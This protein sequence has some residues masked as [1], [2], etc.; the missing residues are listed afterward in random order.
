MSKNPVMLVPDGMDAAFDIIDGMEGMV[1]E[2]G[3]FPDKFWKKDVFSRYDS[4]AAKMNK[5]HKK[6]TMT[7]KELQ[8]LIDEAAKLLYD[9]IDGL[10]GVVSEQGEV[11]SMY[12]K[13]G[14]MNAAKKAYSALKRA[15]VASERVAAKSL[16]VHG[17]SWGERPI[18]EAKKMIKRLGGRILEDHVFESTDG[19]YK[20]YIWAMF[21]NEK[22]ADKYFSF[23]KRKLDKARY[24]D[25]SDIRKYASVPGNK[26]AADIL[27]VAGKLE[28]RGLAT[29]IVVK[30]FLIGMDAHMDALIEA[31]ERLEKMQYQET[32]AGGRE[33]DQ[34]ITD[35]IE[36]IGNNLEQIDEMIFAVK[37]LSRKMR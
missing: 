16:A 15:K 32:G 26:M 9:L 35:A 11:P 2:T 31:K 36:R 30:D 19:D 22:D 33:E 5:A 24:L 1:S 10:E 18:E 29:N 6:G 4:L 23:A 28:A 34:G 14:V 21:D 20:N 13:R 17:S 3:E 25:Q 8:G 7:G 27:K 12:W 37:K